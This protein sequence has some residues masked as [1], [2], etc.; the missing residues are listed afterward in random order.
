M[1]MTF[2]PILFLARPGAE[3]LSPPPRIRLAGGRL[4]RILHD[5]VA[6]RTLH[7]ILIWV[8]VNHGMFAAEIVP[9]WRRRN[10]PLER[11]SVPRV[12]R[13]RRTLITAIYQIEDE[14]ELRCA[15]AECRDGDEL[16][17]RQQRS[18]II[19]YERRITPHVAHQSEVM[20]RHENAIGANEG[21]PEMKLAQGFVHHPAGHLAEP[22]VRAGKDAENRRH[23]HH[24]V[25]MAD[26]EIRGVQ[27]DV[28][29]GLSQEKA[30]NDP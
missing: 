19:I 5:E 16:V 26:H 11:R 28:D 29:R 8:V 27:H 23:A 3:T 22:E 30:R 21:E 20:E 13:S 12:F 2:F 9:R 14:D 1:S 7:I 17:Q 10:T 15:R 6:F 25:E 4:R 18:S 24:H